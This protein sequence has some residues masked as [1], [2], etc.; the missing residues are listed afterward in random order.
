MSKSKTP[1]FILELGLKVNVSQEARLK[2]RFEAG[3]QFYNAILDESKRRLQLLKESKAFSVARK[4]PKGKERT[5]AFRELN[6]KFEFREYDLHRYCTQIRQSWIGQHLDSNTSQKITS[7]AF[8]TV[9]KLS[10]G[11]S[12]KVHFKRAN[13][14]NSMEGKCNGSGIRF[15]DNQI[16]WKNLSLDCIIDQSDPVIAHGLKQKVKFCRLIRR[17]LKGRT[18]YF[19]QLVLAGSPYQKY[20]FPEAEVGLDVGPSTIAHVHLA[21]AEL[22]TFCQPLENRQKEIRQLSRKLDRQRRANNPQNYQPNGTI[23]PGYKKW[24]DS[25]QYLKTKN[26]ISEIKRK[27]AAH[28]KSLH[29]NM[30]NRIL[31][32]GKIVKTE[33]VSYKS[34]QRNFGKSVGFRAPG[35]LIEMLRRKAENVG[36]SV[37]EFST[38]TTKLSQYCH[39]CDQYHKKPLSQRVHSHCGL[40]IQRDVYSAFL[41]LNVIDDVL[42][43]PSVNDRWRSM[44]TVLRATSLCKENQ[45]AKVR[46]LSSREPN[47]SLE[48][49]VH[50]V[51]VKLDKAPDVVTEE[52]LS[53]FSLREPVRV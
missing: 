40:N 49:L 34:F 29:G 25:N 1:S 9:Q 43:V 45:V 3:R 26:K 19:V 37:T 17:K 14:L 31:K 32:Q 15:K 46:Q 11:R 50:E 16:H 35:M 53:L 48:R 28:R 41:A 2:A 47:G 8:A 30:A 6:I 21:G 33:K 36:G 23:K 24:H 52:Q 20:Q 39:A 38:R 27:Q 10:F 13:E 4:L 44:E 42:D 7:R 18:R 22:E 5:N 12:K 51:K